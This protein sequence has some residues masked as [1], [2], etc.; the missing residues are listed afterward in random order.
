M[1]EEFRDRILRR[2]QDYQAV[3]AGPVGE[4]V[5]AD[6]FRFGGMMQPSIRVSPQMG[7]ID[8]LAIAVAEGRRELA[9]RIARFCSLSYTEVMNIAIKAED[10]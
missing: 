3:F 2:A 9:L 8:P 6:I 4:R 1:I 10:D 5:L 7:T